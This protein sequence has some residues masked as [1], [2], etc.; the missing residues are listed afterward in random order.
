MKKDIIIDNF[1]YF[2]QYKRKINFFY[3]IF[4][5]KFIY[6]FFSLV[7]ITKFMDM[8]VSVMTIF[9]IVVMYAFYSYTN[10]SLVPKYYE[11]SKHWFVSHIDR[12][13]NED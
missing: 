3:F 10:S 4:E 9:F 8:N 5:K 12:L 2:T 6:T 7:G 11:I 13:K 1:I